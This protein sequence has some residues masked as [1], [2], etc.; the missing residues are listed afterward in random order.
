M[1]EINFG[2]RK[3]HAFDLDGTLAPGS[4]VERAFSNLLE[5]G[6]LNLSDDEIDG[7]LSFRDVD[8]SEYIRQAVR[9]FSDGIRGLQVKY[10]RRIARMIAQEDVTNIYPEMQNILDTIKEDGEDIVIIS[11]SPRMFVEAFGHEIGAQVSDG[12]HH[13]SA[14]GAIH[15]T[16]PR[17]KA[18]WE[19]D[20][21][22]ISICRSIGGQ[23]VSAYGNAMND[24]S[25]LAR[26]PRP[27]AVNPLPN[28]REAALERDW[29][30]IDCDLAVLYIP[31]GTN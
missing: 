10:L 17:R 8:E 29:P 7:I 5:R 22:L 31:R 27:T 18:I 23:A 24:F 6:D 15:E 25:M 26:V 12:T 14:R 11:G 21:H 20:K 4:L 1:T 2:E 16:R 19:K 30:I 3:V 13:F 9:G 28:L